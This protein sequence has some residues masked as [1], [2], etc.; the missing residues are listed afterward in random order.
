MKAGEFRETIRVA[1]K[2]AILNPSDATLLQGVDELDSAALAQAPKDPEVLAFVA[3]LRHLQ[4]R[5]DEE[6]ELYRMVLENKPSSY[7]FLNNMAWTLCEGLQRYDEALEKIDEVIRRHGAFPA[8]LDTRGVILAR[9]GR[10]D[11]AIADLE[12]SAKATP[13]ASTFFH[14]AR[15]YRQANKLDDYRRNR[16]LARKAKLDP[17]S[18]DPTDKADLSSVMDGK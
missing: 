14:L 11:P 12:Q 13:S 10:L 9:L 1:T 3:T 5:Y 17:T 8:F 2:I 4:G 16:D 15:T 18:L 7:V 6:I